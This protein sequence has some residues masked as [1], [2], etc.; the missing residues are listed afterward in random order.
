MA[1]TASRRAAETHD[2]DA[3]AI[4]VH[5][6]GTSAEPKA[7]ELTYGQLAAG[8]RWARPSALGVDPAERW[9]CC[10]PLSHVGGLSILLR[11][12][13]Y[14]TSAIVHERFDADRVI[15]ALRDPQGPTL[16]SLVPTTLA[17]LL[18]AGL[19]RPPALRWALLGGAPIAPSLIERAERDGRPGR[20]HLWHDRGL[21]AGRHQRAPAVLHSRRNRRRR[22]DPRQRADR[23]HRLRGRC[24][25]REISASWT[26]T[27][28]L[29]ITGRR[30][31]T[32]I[33][34]GENVAPQE[35]EAALEAHP[36]VAEAAVH[37]ASDPQ[38]GEAIVATIVLR[39]GA[40]ASEADLKSWCGERLAAFKAPK[41]IAFATALPR[42][43]SG[44]LARRE[45]DRGARD[46]NSDPNG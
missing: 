43:G 19:R 21:L 10:L 24:F 7:V 37:A 33:S 15:A 14:G 42:T 1:R 22:R 31:D 25:T 17:R 6:S 40:R 23:W 36:A 26:P 11:S 41:R 28:R 29:L 46:P 35:V 30:A 34:G 3:A 2:L 8:A 38:W 4:V 16:V 20:P 5:T 18:D 39:P 44:K 32:I 45:L 27:G 9:L 12:A 13:I